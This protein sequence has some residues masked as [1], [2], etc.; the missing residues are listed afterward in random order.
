M[1][2]GASVF[3]LFLFISGCA[4]VELPLEQ[5]ALNSCFFENERSGWHFEANPPQDAEELRQLITKEE[6]H[7]ASFDS[8]SLL[9]WFIHDDGRKYVC[10]LAY[11]GDLPSICG[12]IAYELTPSGG[13][14]RVEQQALVSCLERRR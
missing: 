6:R 7:P 11:V 8:P 4:T 10:S 3:G 9:Y 5:R 14:W 13:S 12:R 1:R 2:R